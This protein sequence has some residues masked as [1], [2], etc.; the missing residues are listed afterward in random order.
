MN[1]KELRSKQMLK[2]SAES[3]QKVLA[4][5]IGTPLSVLAEEPKMNGMY[6]L[7][8][9]HLPVILEGESIC[10]NVIYQITPYT[11]DGIYLYA[12]V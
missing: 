5:F 6:G 7:S 4:Q 10:E 12:K 1:M 9:N 11:T 8:E 3:E 2:L